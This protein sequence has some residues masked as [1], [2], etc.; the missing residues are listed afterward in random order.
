[1]GFEASVSAAEWRRS[2][3]LCR[4]EERTSE[5]IA[6]SAENTILRPS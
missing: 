6:V 1:M 2:L 5:A 4:L 3:W